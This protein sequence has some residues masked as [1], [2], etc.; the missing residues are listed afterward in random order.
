MTKINIKY[1]EK[2]VLLA[3]LVIGIVLTSGCTQ[4]S[5]EI[6]QT[7]IPNGVQ[8]TSSVSFSDILNQANTISSVKYDIIITMPGLPTLTTNTWIKDDMIRT[9]MTVEGMKVI[10]I[11]GRGGVMY[12]YMP[13]QNMAMKID[14]GDAPVPAVDK[15]ESMQGYDPKVI[16]TETLDGKKCQVIEIPEG[17]M[18][19]WDEYGFPIR[20]EMTLPE[21]KVTTEYRNIEFVD[22][23]D[24]MFE[25]PQGVMML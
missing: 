17:K 5:E 23:P 11:V 19:I 2:M 22:I 8:T 25:L 20:I 21:G 18:W 7:S 6:Q 12:T 4:T 10:N 1:L 13:D 14:A 9:E 16:G 24:S 3:V 15:L